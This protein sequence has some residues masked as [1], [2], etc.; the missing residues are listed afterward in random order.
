MKL[1]D[2]IASIGVII[3][4][5]AFLLNLYRKLSQGSRTYGLMN[6]IG[7]AICAFAAY[8]VSF[9]PFIILESA[10]SIF[11]LVSIFKNQRNHGPAN[12]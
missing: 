3:L 2:V 6:F 4:L 10:W 9:Y 12:R 8:L 5:A 7:A 11:A 1:S